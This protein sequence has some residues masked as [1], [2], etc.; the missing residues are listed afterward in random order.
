MAVIDHGHSH[1]EPRSLSSAAPEPAP[2]HGL[3]SGI[4]FLAFWLAF[5]A[6]VW[7]LHILIDRLF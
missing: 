1:L 7:V 2:I 4:G 6:A 5:L 3:M